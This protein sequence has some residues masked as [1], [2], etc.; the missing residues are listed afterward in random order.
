MKTYQNDI[1]FVA[2]T[3]KEDPTTH[4]SIYVIASGTEKIDA[5]GIALKAPSDATS[6]GRVEA[7]KDGGVTIDCGETTR[8]ITK[9]YI[10]IKSENP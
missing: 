4:K 10:T 2:Y 8:I 6:V 7:G 9:I 3:I 1:D 5:I